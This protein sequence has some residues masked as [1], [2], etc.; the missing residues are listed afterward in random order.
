P[1]GGSRWAP[2]RGPPRSWPSSPRRGRPGSGAM[3]ELPEVETI[4]AVLSRELTGKKI[5]SVTVTNGKLTKRHKSVKEFRA[6]LEGATVKSVGRLG[7]NL[8]IGLDSGNHL[9]VHLGMSGQ[10]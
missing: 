2:A 5:K 3:P 10:L 7:K 1:A 6:L 4:R 8:V 9:V